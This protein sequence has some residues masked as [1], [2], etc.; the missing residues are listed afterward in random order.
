[1]R[2]P[3]WMDEKEVRQGVTWF[4]YWAVW[5]VTNI[6]IRVVQKAS[7]NGGNTGAPTTPWGCQRDTEGL[8]ALLTSRL[9]QD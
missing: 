6:E 4:G 2:N 7:K 3:L 5:P 1:V 8:G 9:G